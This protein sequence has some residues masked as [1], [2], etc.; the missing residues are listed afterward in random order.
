[1][2]NL[3]YTYESVWQGGDQNGQKRPKLFLFPY[4]STN[5]NENDTEESESGTSI[6]ACQ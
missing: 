6:A 3:T 4:F 1:M 5:K 2:T